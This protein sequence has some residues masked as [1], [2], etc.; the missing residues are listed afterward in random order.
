MKTKTRVLA[1]LLALLALASVLAG[2]KKKEEKPSGGTGKLIGDDSGDSAGKNPYADVDFGGRIFQVHINTKDAG[3]ESS[4]KYIIPVEEL[5][6]K[7]NE[8]EKEVFERDAWMAENLNM[9]IE[10]TPYSAEYNVVVESLRVLVNSGVSYDLFIDKLFPMANF[11]LEGHFENVAGRSELQYFENYWYNDYMNSLSLDEG[12]TMYLLAGDYFID[13]LRS[14]N[15]MFVNLDM[16]DD[17]FPDA[18]GSEQFLNDVIDGKW[19][20]EELMTRSEAVYLAGDTVLTTRYG[21]LFHTVWEPLIPMIVAGGATFAEVSDGELVSKMTDDRNVRLFGQLKALLNSENCDTCIGGNGVDWGLNPAF[22]VDAT[23]SNIQT[24]FVN[25][26]GLFTYGRFASMETLGKTALRYS[27]LP[28]PKSN[29]EDSYITASHD[30]TE[31]GGIPK[32][33]ENVGEILQMLDIL[34]ALSNKNLIQVY[35]EET[36]KIRYSSNKQ[37]ASVV[38]IIHDNMGSAFALAYSEACSGLLLWHSYYV[39]LRDGRD[40]LVTLQSNSAPLQSALNTLMKKWN[41]IS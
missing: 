2:C 38:D 15:V 39:P 8:L 23:L 13:V 17:C 21:L 20:Y 24:I 14:S 30:T 32:G 26:H 12:S 25:G 19:T 6:S 31:L 18:G 22:G 29:A 27:A 3:F 36:L 41:E 7:C 37:A 5:D 35:Y 1:L 40:Y 10:Y 11:S 9:D 28:Y 16:L 34:S 4:S 33:A